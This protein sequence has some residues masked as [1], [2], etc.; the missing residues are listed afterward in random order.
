MAIW[1]S[2]CL[3]E[4]SVFQY[5]KFAV[6]SVW[7]E[8]SSSSR[9]YLKIRLTTQRPKSCVKQMGF[10]KHLRHTLLHP[11][12]HQS[13]TNI[14]SIPIS[15]YILI[16]TDFGRSQQQQQGISQDQ[17]DDITTIILYKTNGI[18]E[19]FSTSYH[20]PIIDHYIIYPPRPSMN[21][22]YLSYPSFP[23][24]LSSLPLYFQVTHD[25]QAT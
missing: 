11:I 7:E 9:E 14:S 1:T 10:M 25:F 3:Y 21:P 5:S 15:P 6:M 12:I 13:L 24:C 20:P 23:H 8:A 16:I 18:H 2:N 4:E 17:G 22:F 19:V